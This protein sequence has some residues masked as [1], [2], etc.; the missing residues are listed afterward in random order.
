MQHIFNWFQDF[1]ENEQQYFVL[2]DYH[3]RFQME[4]IMISEMQ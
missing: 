3:Y 1:I 4:W 2:Y